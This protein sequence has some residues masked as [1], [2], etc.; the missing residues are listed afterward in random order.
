M[1]RLGANAFIYADDIIILSPTCYTL[2]RLIM[3]CEGFSEEF[4]LSFNPDKSAIL[5]FSDITFIDDIRL[6]IFGRKIRIVLEEKHLGHVLSS[7]GSLVN[8]DSVIKDMKVGTNIIINQ[9]QFTSLTSKIQLFNS[10][11]MSLYGS[12][13]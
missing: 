4:T 5:L 10:Q 3:I 13:L 8:I 1:G 12:Q 2:C 9:F 6:T 11:C 7:R